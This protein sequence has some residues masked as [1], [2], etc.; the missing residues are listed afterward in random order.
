MNLEKGAFLFYDFLIKKC[1]ETAFVKELENISA[2]ET[3]HARLIYHLFPRDERST[4]MFQDVFGALPGDIIEGGQPLEKVCRGLERMPGAFLAN[5]L[6]MAL[7]IE[8]AGYDLYRTLANRSED[9]QIQKVLLTLS[10]A[11]KKHVYQVAQ[12]FQNA[13]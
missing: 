1:A 3:A 4:E 2:M 8:Y 5:A 10:Q 12:L 6:D 7:Y 13:F 11:E 9:P